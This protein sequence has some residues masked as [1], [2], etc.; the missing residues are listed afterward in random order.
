MPGKAQGI[1]G[2]TARKQ[3]KPDHPGEFTKAILAA[4]PGA[5]ETV[6]EEGVEADARRS[7]EEGDGTPVALE[8]YSATYR[9]NKAAS[10]PKLE[11]SREPATHAAKPARR[12]RA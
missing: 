4:P 7:L 12:P 3:R 5:W 11:V 2:L 6:Q 10:R 9:R 1:R 8:E